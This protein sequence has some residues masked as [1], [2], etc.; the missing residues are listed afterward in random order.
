MNCMKAL[1]NNQFSKIWQKIVFQVLRII[2]KHKSETQDDLTIL[3]KQFDVR[4]NSPTV[5][6][7]GDSVVERISFYDCDRRPLWKMVQSNLK[8]KLD[9]ICIS[10][11]AYHTKMFYYIINTFRKMRQKPNYVILPI[12]TLY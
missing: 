12:C 9:V 2:F 4:K 7:L 6:F 10:H 8:D 1:K 5:L 3:L 11:S